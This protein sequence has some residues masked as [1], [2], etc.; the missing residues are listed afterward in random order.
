MAS[1]TSL[2]EYLSFILVIP[3]Y[4]IFLQLAF[5]PDQRLLFKFHPLTL[6]MNDTLSSIDLQQLVP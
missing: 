5:A 3:L 2:L 1:K 4:F 6:L